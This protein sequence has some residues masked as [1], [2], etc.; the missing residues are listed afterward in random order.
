MNTISIKAK[1]LLDIKPKNLTDQEAI[2]SA[3]GAFIQDLA[4]L[5]TKM[6]EIEK[7]MNEFEDRLDEVELKTWV[8]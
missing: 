3:F 4:R 5:E 6:N 1:D 7:K 2:D 8:K